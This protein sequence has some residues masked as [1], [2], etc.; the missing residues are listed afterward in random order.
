MADF[1]KY[2]ETVLKYEGGHSADPDDNAL[3]TGHTGVKGKTINPATGKP[4][5]ADYP[6]NYIHTNKG[7]LWSG[8]KKYKKDKGQTPDLNEYLQMSKALWID[9]YKTMYWDKVRGDEIKLQPIA[10]FLL[11]AKWLGGG[12][13]LINDIQKYLKIPVTGV[14]DNATLTA[15]NTRFKNP[16]NLEIFANFM[17]KARMAYLSSLSDWNKYKGGW[18]KRTKNLLDRAK[19]FIAQMKFFWLWQL[20]PVVAIGTFFF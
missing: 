8:Y 12:M 20:L 2:I 13:R 4:Y 6:N 17:Y 9:Y 14:I 19:S 15:L 5:D 7:I 10:E 1:K 18:S 16:K 3:K 11:D